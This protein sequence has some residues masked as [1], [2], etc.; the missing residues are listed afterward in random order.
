MKRYLAAVLSVA[1]LTGGTGAGATSVAGTAQRHASITP[2]PIGTVASGE[3]SGLA[4]P[5]GGLAGYQETYATDFPGT[6]L[7]AGWDAYTGQPGGDP[8]AQFAASHLNVANG[9]LTLTSSRDPQ[10]GNNWVTGGV[11]DC[12][13]VVTY[14]A[15][16]VRSRVNGAGPASVEL[17]WPANNSW[18]PEI[19]FNETNGSLNS[20]TATVHF[21]AANS[22]IQRRISVNMAV[23][24]TWGVVWSPR[25]ITYIL[26]GRAWATVRRGVPTVP[27]RLSLQQQTQCSSGWA[28]PTVTTTMQVAWVA[29]YAPLRRNPISQPGTRRASA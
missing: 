29:Q 14:G 17:L 2:Y 4:P 5:R 12:G 3:P 21:G 1:L 22:T 13:Q 20:S 24:H 8:G 23:W 11:C 6:S 18:P 28:C 16:F 19:D 25:S 9:M 15:W 10:W 26:D 27:M 7:P